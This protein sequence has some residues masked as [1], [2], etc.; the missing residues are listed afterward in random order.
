M[1]A[2]VAAA[3]AAADLGG[4]AFKE[5][6]EAALP[7]IGRRVDHALEPAVAAGRHLRATRHE[8]HSV[9]SATREEEGRQTALWTRSERRRVE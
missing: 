9:S 2:E 8:R 3:A 6:A 4:L 5:L 7:A 1:A